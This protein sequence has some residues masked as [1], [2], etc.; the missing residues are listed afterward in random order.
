MSLL[1]SG[2]KTATIAGTQMQCVELYAGESYTMPLTFTNS[3]GSP[4]NCTGW[5]L[6]TAAKWYTCQVEFPLSEES[7]VPISITALE[8]ITPQPSA[9][10]T[11]LATFTTPASGLGY[12]FLPTTLSGST[13]GTTPALTDTTTL[14]CI[15]TMTVTRTDPLS[16]LVDV[17]K[18]PIGLI[19]R[20]V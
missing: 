3:A 4:L 13:A 10:S 17:N 2:A 15:L 11:S 16:S 7:I 1:L 8:L 19:I 5:A 14:L 9:I 6:S 20:Y 12:L 18:E